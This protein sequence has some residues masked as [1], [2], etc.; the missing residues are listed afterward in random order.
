MGT[1]Q[2]LNM[3]GNKTN[4]SHYQRQK[5]LILSEAIKYDEVVNGCLQEMFKN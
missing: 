3:V 4:D 2:I 5:N 1:I